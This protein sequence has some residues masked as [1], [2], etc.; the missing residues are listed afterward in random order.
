[1]TELCLKG[2]ITAMISKYMDD[3]ISRLS[4]IAEEH[5]KPHDISLFSIQCEYDLIKDHLTE[6]V[7]E[8]FNAK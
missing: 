3:E 8:I 1:M 6:N 2:K 5:K 4:L 7:E